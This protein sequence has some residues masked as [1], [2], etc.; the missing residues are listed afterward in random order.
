VRRTQVGAILLIAS[1]VILT[2]GVAIVWV[3]SFGD[4]D[5]DGAQNAR[6]SSSPDRRPVNGDGPTAETTGVPGGVNLRPSG[7]LKITHAGAVVE[8]LDVTGTIVIDAPDVTIRN[9]R[10][11][12]TG[13]MGVKVE[14]GSLLIEDSEIIGMTDDCAQGVAWGDYVAARI[15]V[16]GCQDG[17]KGNGNVAVY[18]SYIHDLRPTP[19]S[20]NDGFQS[21]GGS[22]ITIEG[23]TICGQFRDSVSAVKLTPEEQAIDNVVIRNNVLRGG[24]FTLYMDSKP[25]TFGVVTNALVEDNTIVAG[26]YAHKWQ[27]VDSDPTQTFTNNVEADVDVC[28]LGAG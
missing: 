18:D 17:L 6:A 11:R 26:S 9:T 7:S 10:I 28:G 2:V 13:S 12:A 4:R 16:S 24:N 3:S 15:D 8:G 22:D 14:S 20:H 5:G 19:S 27:N 23:N 1:V 25:N 21:T